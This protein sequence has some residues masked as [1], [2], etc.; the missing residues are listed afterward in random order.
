L[1]PLFKDILPDHLYY[2]YLDYAVFL[3]LLCQESVNDEDLVE[4]DNLIH[5][6]VSEFEEDYTKDGMHYNLH[7]HLHLASQVALY[8]PLN[9]TSCFPFENMFKIARSY[10]HGT[11]GYIEQIAKNTIVNCALNQNLRKW[12]NEIKDT[13]L[14]AYLNRISFNDSV[15]GQISHTRKYNLINIEDLNIQNEILKLGLNEFD[16]I[17]EYNH[18]IINKKSNSIY[19]LKILIIIKYY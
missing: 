4:A 12:I 10:I 2:H 17:I 6:F 8:G 15:M 11:H 19:F 5:S 18:L 3:R 9:K 7:A 16:N 13:N 14:K 1:T